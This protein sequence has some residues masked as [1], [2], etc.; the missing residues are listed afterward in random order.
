VQQVDIIIAG[1][2]LAGLS[3]AYSLTEIS[4]TSI[5]VLTDENPE[6]ASLAA[7]GI[8]NPIT[9]RRHVKTWM[10]DTLFPV[11]FGFYRKLEEQTGEKFFS[12]LSIAELFDS[13]KTKNDWL[14]RSAEPGYEDYIG[15]EFRSDYF[16]T[17]V[18]APLGGIFIRNTAMVSTGK[19][20]SAL[21]KMLSNRNV[22]F[23]ICRF[24]HDEFRFEKDYAEFRNV[25]SQKVVFCEGW[26]MIHNPYFN[27]HR[28]IP[29]K[30][31]LL[32]FESRDLQIDCILMGEGFICPLGENRFMAGSTYDWNFSDSSPDMEAGKKIEKHIQKIIRV[33]FKVIDHRAGIRPAMQSRR[34]VAEIHQQI[35]QAAVFNGLGTKGYLLAPYFSKKLAAELVETI[36]VRK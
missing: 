27:H 14:I 17:A 6:A 31:D 35:K 13:Y 33:P 10:A 12:M 28:M 20:I 7:A 32:I 19:F 3:L 25:K 5:L 22:K 1:G 21:K 9:G 8:L 2:G 11:A 26:K 34:P 24:T 4:D 15:L 16:G 36:A 18:H 29:V 23:E 30:G